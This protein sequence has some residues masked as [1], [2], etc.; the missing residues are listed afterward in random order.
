[1]TGSKGSPDFCTVA[2]IGSTY[3]V[4]GWVKLTVRSESLEQFLQFDSLFLQAPSTGK[5]YP[6]LFEEIKPHGRG[7]VAKLPGCDNK[8]QAALFTG[9]SVGVQWDQLPQLEEGDFYWAD[10]VGMLVESSEGQLYGVVD[11]LMETGS[12]DVL[13]V[14]PIDGS[15]DNKERLIPYLIDSVILKVDQAKQSILVEWDSEF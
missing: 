11:G 3:G 5:W 9:R 6:L 10:L 8:E 7:L 1:M 4:H 15:I 14:H 13:I 2:T 12:N